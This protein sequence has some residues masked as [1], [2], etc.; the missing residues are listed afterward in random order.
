MRML[1]AAKME[2]FIPIAPNSDFPLNN[3]PYGACKLRSDAAKTRLFVAI[4]DHVVDLGQLQDAG[5]FSGPILSKTKCFTQVLD[6]AHGNYLYREQ[7]SAITDYK[8]HIHK[9]WFAEALLCN[10][11]AANLLQLPLDVH[12][13]SQ[14]S[15]TLHVV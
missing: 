4:G 15:C 1:P 11:C 13:V 6:C 7:L 2:S 9:P 8:I 14:Q 3:L 10:C 5:C 12:V